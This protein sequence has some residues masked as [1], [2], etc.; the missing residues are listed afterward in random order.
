MSHS[1]S[2]IRDHGKEKV[3]FKI[4]NI[5]LKAKKKITTPREIRRLKGKFPL[6][7]KEIKLIQAVSVHNTDEVKRLLESGVNP[8]STDS[9]LRSALHVA[10]SK[11]Y[12]DIVK[13]LLDYG[14]D[15]NTRD[16]ILNTPLHLAACI[17]NFAI[18]SLLINAKADVSCLDIHGRNPLQLA[19]SK[20][21]ILQRG[22]REGAIE[23]T[24]LR[25][26]VQQVVDLLLSI[27]IRGIEEKIEKS[28]QSD[29]DNLQIMKLSL[30]S[31]PPEELDDQMSKLLSDIEKFKLS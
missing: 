29:V 28:N 5:E 14:A 16:V 22:W 8:N 2:E 6:F 15:P 20:L 21:E 25:E 10:V 9:Q 12:V 24:K 4:H 1:D 17:H 30:N 26:E 27:L 3:Q 11:G 7:Y 18:I 23:M 13:L 19:S 31:G